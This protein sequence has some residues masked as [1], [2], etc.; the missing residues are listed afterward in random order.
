MG[1]SGDQGAFRALTC[2]YTHWASGRLKEMEVNISHPSYCHVRCV[3]N[4]SMRQ[5]VYNVYMLLGREELA[6]ICSATC[7][8]TAG[9]VHTCCYPLSVCFMC[10]THVFVYSVTF[11]TGSQLC[12]CT[13]VVALLHALS[14]LHP[15]AFNLK[16]NVHSAGEHADDETP[17]TSLPCQWKPPKK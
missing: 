10:H 15:L 3:M 9:Y 16:P 2:G 11:F 13:H 14:S 4:P 6:T 8:C 7:E 17:V 5:G 1:C 12:S